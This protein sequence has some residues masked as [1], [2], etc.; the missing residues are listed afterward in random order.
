MA[1][2]LYA[3]SRPYDRGIFFSK[4]QLINWRDGAAWFWDCLV[5][6]DLASNSASWQW[7]AGCGADAAPYFRIFNPVLQSKKFDPEGNY[8][9][10]YCPELTGLSGKNL[11]QPWEAKSNMLEA[12][13][14]ELGVHY[15]KPILDLKVTR[16]RALDVDRSL[17]V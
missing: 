5:D 14:I 12:A 15:P 11:H 7:T 1:N 4:N 17:V 3:Q 10:Q 2:G 16:Q 8:I 13:G 6:A 9:K